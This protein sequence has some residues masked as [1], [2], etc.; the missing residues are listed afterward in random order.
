M[1]PYHCSPDRAR[2][3]RTRR[4]PNGSAGPLP[5]LGIV[6]TTVGLLLFIA[7][8]IEMPAP[9]TPMRLGWLHNQVGGDLATM[10]RSPTGPRRARPHPR[11]M[12]WSA[13][14]NAGFGDRWVSRVTS[15]PTRD[16]RIV[17]ARVAVD[18]TVRTDSADVGMPPVSSGSGMISVD[19]LQPRRLGCKLQENTGGL[20]P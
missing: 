10:P 2:E 12:A 6:F 19:L 5:L 9:A 8:L 3:L 11:V 1:V 14:E 13:Q 7:G 17:S 18:P 20:C 4:A 16:K 15:S